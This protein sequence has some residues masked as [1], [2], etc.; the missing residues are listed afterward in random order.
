MRWTL[1]ARTSLVRCGRQSE[2]VG[3]KTQSPPLQRAS[4]LPQRSHFSAAGP[5]AVHSTLGVVQ[6]LVALSQM[7]SPLHQ[8][9]PAQPP[10]PVMGHSAHVG[11]RC[12]PHS[13][14]ASTRSR[15]RSGKTLEKRD[16]AE[17]RMVLGTRV[18]SK[19]A[20]FSRAVN[21]V[22][23]PCNPHKPQTCTPCRAAG[24]GVITT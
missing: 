23:Q 13:T 20:N 22:L 1:A 12:P 6:E 10:E 19:L 9:E 11:A 7:Q 15:K 14:S 5:F 24:Q 8:A 17:P 18:V 16:V 21:S 4:D 3:L 2:V